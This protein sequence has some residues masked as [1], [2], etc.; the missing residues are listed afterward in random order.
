[1]KGGD[2][3]AERKQKEVTVA[4]RLGSKESQ[5]LERVMDLLEE[6]TGERN[7][8]AA[9]RYIVANFDIEASPLGKEVALVA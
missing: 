2:M 1:M 7:V 8:S 4:A 6:L 3:A 5:K 9:L